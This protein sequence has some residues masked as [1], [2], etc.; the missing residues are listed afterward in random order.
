MKVISAQQAAAL[1]QSQWT[2]A[3]AGFVGAGHAEAVTDALERRFLESGLPPR[4]DAA[5]VFGG[6]GRSRRARGEPHSAAG[7]IAALSA[8]A[9]GAPPRGW[10]RL[11]WPS[12]AKAY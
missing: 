11:P 2:V 1:V 3:S 7:M 9:T 6:A 12:S 8:A 10:R 5:S 4:P